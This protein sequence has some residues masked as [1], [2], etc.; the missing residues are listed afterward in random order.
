[1]EAAH[2]VFGPYAFRKRYREND[3]RFPIN[4]ALFE[5][6]TVNLARRSDEELDL[7][8]ARCD[9][10]QTGLVDLLADDPEFERSISQGTG[11]IGKV[12]RRFGSVKN[13]FDGVVNA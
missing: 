4:K 7:L 2:A 6:V 5:A 8:T 3:R 12:R 11:D 13:L 10:V 1:M 9:M